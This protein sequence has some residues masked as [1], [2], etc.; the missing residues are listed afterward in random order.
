MAPPL[1]ALEAACSLTVDHPYLFGRSG[2]EVELIDLYNGRRSKGNAVGNKSTGRVTVTFEGG[3]VLNLPV[4]QFLGMRYSCV[5]PRTRSDTWWTEPVRFRCQEGGR[6]MTPPRCPEEYCKDILEAGISFS[7]EEVTSADLAGLLKGGVL[8]SCFHLNFCSV[9]N[10]CL[11]CVCLRAR[12]AALPYFTV[13]LHLSFSVPPLS[14]SWSRSLSF[15]SVSRKLSIMLSS[16]S[17]KYPSLTHYILKNN[18]SLV[19]NVDYSSNL[20]RAFVNFVDT[21]IKML[22]RHASQGC[23][24]PISD[25]SV[26][27]QRL[28]PIVRLVVLF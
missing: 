23:L 28:D 5:N 4:S 15:L 18:G 19:K 14:F 22:F 20:S 25:H 17:D 10:V 21:E 9:S 26:E 16:F 8:M 7:N 2:R 24:G 3:E 13:F 11:E 12:V 6:L 1:E 27:K